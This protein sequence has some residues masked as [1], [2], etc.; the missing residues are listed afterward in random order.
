MNRGKEMLLIIALKFQLR[1][2]C[3][4][5]YYQFIFNELNTA[6][7][8]KPVRVLATFPISITSHY[9]SSLISTLYPL[10]SWGREPVV[11]F[12]PSMAS[13]TMPY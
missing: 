1:K 9:S 3:P 4:N 13:K 6:V 11:S 12:V 10:F 7:D 5:R 8:L 2:S